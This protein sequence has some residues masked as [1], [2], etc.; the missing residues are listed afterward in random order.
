MRRALTLLLLAALPA[1]PARTEAGLFGRRLRVTDEPS[2]EEPRREEAKPKPAEEP[3]DPFAPAKPRPEGEKPSPEGRPA[4]EKQEGE[5]PRE[6][7]KVRIRP[8][9][10]AKPEKDVPTEARM[11]FRLSRI[12]K[13]L[14]PET[15]ALFREGWS[16]VLSQYAKVDGRLE[17]LPGAPLPMRL[18]LRQDLG[19]GRWLANA[20]WN[21]PGVLAW[22][23]PGPNESQVVV[24][25]DAP[26]QPGDRRSVSALRIGLV[27]ASFVAQIPPA[28]GRRVTVRRQAFVE[29]APLAD[30]EATRR[31]FQQAVESGQELRA[32]V[33][34][35]R[36]CRPC[37]GLGYVRRKV[38]GR[39][40]DARDPCPGN[41][42]HGR[43]KVGLELSFK[44]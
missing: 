36:D 21:N 12:D 8:I 3:E 11:E 1:I 25:L 31:A 33:V 15:S 16:A 44:P 14:A 18:T 26:G 38:P 17:R 19:E 28:E 32:L 2:R 9:E 43:R 4:R 30:D 42:D 29:T 40:Q 39:I 24:V 23:R 5:P 37:G 6:D 34:Q 22:C 13:P 20:S 10:M 35:E 41:C 27:E 7:G